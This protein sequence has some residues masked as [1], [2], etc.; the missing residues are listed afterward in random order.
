MSTHTPSPWVLRGKSS[1]EEHTIVVYAQDPAI[2]QSAVAYVFEHPDFDG[3]MLVIQY[4]PDMLAALKSL[5][6]I[7]EQITVEKIV[8][9]RRIIAKVEAPTHG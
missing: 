8:K 1:F 6:D 5:V 3:D 9:A 7:G 2:R 4:A